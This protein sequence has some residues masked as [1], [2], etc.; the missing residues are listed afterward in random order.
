[1][2]LLAA[3]QSALFD[4]FDD[5]DICL[6]GCFCSVCLYGQNAERIDESS[7]FVHMTKRKALRE[8]FDLLEDCD[9]CLVTTF[10]SSCAICQEARELD[11]RL[12]SSSNVVVSQPTMIRTDQTFASK[13][14]LKQQNTLHN[15]HLNGS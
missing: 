14:T 2:L 3:T 9:D 7:C 12:N 10:C 8:R 4:C 13:N 5:G 1:M 11:F 6:Y 15:S